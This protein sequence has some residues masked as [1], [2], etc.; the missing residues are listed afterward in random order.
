LNKK[1]EIIVFTAARQDY[2]E[3][4]INILDPSNHILKECLF[5]QNCVPYKGICM[6]DFGVIENRAKSDLIIIDN[7]MY[8]FALDFANGI[9]IKSY[10]GETGDQ[11]LNVL[12]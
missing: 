2:A 4:I 9:V 5:R 8:S 7:F 10:F 11:E 1:F 3:K 12:A 6:K